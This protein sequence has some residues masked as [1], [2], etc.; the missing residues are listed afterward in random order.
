M[1]AHLR[2]RTCTEMWRCTVCPRAAA[3]TVQTTTGWLVVLCR[4]CFL[5]LVR[6]LDEGIA[7]GGVAL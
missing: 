1:K 7:P 6:V 4:G 3:H 5:G 2:Q